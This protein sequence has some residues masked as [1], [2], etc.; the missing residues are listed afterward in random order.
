MSKATSN[1][2]IC[3]SANLSM[4]LEDYSRKRH[5]DRTPEPPPGPV[6]D[7]GNRFCVQR[8]HARRLHYDLRLE[9]GGALKSWAV[10]KG[11]TLDPAE[12]RLAVM[13]EDHP[14]EYGDF[15][16]TIPEGN[17]GA[18]SVMVWDRGS[19]ELLGDKKVDEQLARGD[20]KFRLHG[21]K[22]NGDFA[23][24]RMKNRGKG[25]EWLLLKKKDSFAQPNWDA[26]KYSR[27]ALTGRTQEE[28]AKG[29]VGRADAGT[30]RRGELPAGATRAEMPSTIVPMQAFAAERPPEG[31]DWIYEVKWDGIRTICFIDHQ[32]VRLT[33]R[34]GN[35]AQA[36]YPEL[37]VI[38]HYIDAETA[39]LDGEIAVLDEQGRPSFALIQP[40]IMVSDANAIAHLARS[41]P[42][43][44]FLFDLLY[45]D[46]YDLRQV[47]LAERKRLLESILKPSPVVRLS[48]HFSGDGRQFLEAARQ[49]GL[50]GI[51]AKRADSRYESKRSRDWIKVK[52]VAQQEFVICGYTHGERDYF[53]ALVLGVYDKNKLRW[54]GNVGTGFDQRLLETIHGLLQPLI[55]SRCPFEEMP[56]IPQVVTW[57]RPERVAAIKFAEWTPDGR[58]RAPVFLGLRLDAE[59][60][61]C[62]REGP[63]TE[64][65]G[66]RDAETRRR[67]DAGTRGRG[68][69]ETRGRGD[70][71]T[72][73]HRD[74]GVPLLSGK[75]ES[76]IL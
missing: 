15:E 61:D 1:L 13:V 39:I 11:P 45:L 21:E 30:R 51:L 48:Q 46:G 2:S 73:G 38:H 54:V 25:N 24:V 33:S 34:K 70:A 23:L 36:Q 65:A 10:P 74:P 57:V 22:L 62:V 35:P 19:Y 42:V 60:Q 41:R 28:I 32:D 43:T 76:A 3:Q 40:R 56:Q 44:L 55:T 69:T 50:E 66:Q 4:P 26:E 29:M 6:A 58:L 59:P 75:A 53:G 18:G 9:I 72:R 20:L 49:Q 5:F 37:G 64:T 7:R 67:G 47:P 16:G 14:L 68:D 63:D 71:E 12:K 52:I 8:H 31:P 17:Y 27:S